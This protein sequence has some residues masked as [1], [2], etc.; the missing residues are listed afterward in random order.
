MKERYP[1]LQPLQVE[2][3]DESLSHIIEEMSGHP[4]N[5][6]KLM[7]NHPDLLRA[8]WSF[9]N[10]SVNGGALGKRLA[11]LVILRVAVHMKSWY[12][13]GSH[14][15]RG[16]ET[17]LSQN[18]IERIALGGSAEGWSE[19]EAALLVAVDELIERHAISAETHGKLGR[20]FTM[21]QIMDVI[22]IHGMYVILGC[23]INTW[24]LELDE[25]V[26]NNLPDS[27]TPA[28][29]AQMLDKAQ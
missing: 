21:A 28:T 14:V 18:D 1:N 6:H 22:A 26:E 9:R 8:W 5:V 7:A 16:L 12:E 15:E 17:G 2:N 25:S 4:I 20:F 24:G 10:H 3:W 23:M 29:F 13:W 19:R 27:F 11:E